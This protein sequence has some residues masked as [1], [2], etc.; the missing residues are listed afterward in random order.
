M[1]HIVIK[2]LVDERAAYL[3]DL[4][5][6]ALRQELRALGFHVGMW[7]VRQLDLVDQPTVDWLI[8]R[9]WA[10]SLIKC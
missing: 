3:Q 9:M 7:K 6:Q 4:F 1:L 10:W 2:I 8:G 5:K